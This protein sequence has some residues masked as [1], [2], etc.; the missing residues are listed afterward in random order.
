MAAVT[1]CGNNAQNPAGT[2]SAIKPSTQAATY[3]VTKAVRGR[4]DS[5][6]Q[7]PETLVLLLIRDD[8]VSLISQCAPID[9]AMKFVNGPAKT[10]TAKAGPAEA[11]SC[12]AG[13]PTASIVFDVLRSSPAVTRND[14][15]LR[16]TSKEGD[17][18]AL[19][20]ADDQL[21]TFAALTGTWTLDSLIDSSGQP[22]NLS[23]V[24]VRPTLTF[25]PR[26]LVGLAPDLG[27]SGRLACNNN[28]VEQIRVAAHRLWF[29][30][31]RQT[32][33]DCPGAPGTIDAVLSLVLE[34]SVEFTAQGNA[35]I[36]GGGVARLSRVLP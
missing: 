33:V 9:I 15:E 20:E 12:V 34:R 35:L 18:S 36:L 21:A 7:H 2:T 25:S 31:S 30:G 14:A 29:F 10:E 4:S 22:V 8:S 5:T 6:G 16:L 13:L 32:M 17:I 3:F 19:R 24:P 1:G 27:A 26:G 11:N 28:D 23:V